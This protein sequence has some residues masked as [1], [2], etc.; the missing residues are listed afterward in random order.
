MGVQFRLEYAHVA[1]SWRGGGGL[2]SRPQATP[3]IVQF[4]TLI[5]DR[6]HHIPMFLLPPKHSRHLLEPPGITLG[7]GFQHAHYP[8]ALDPLNGEHFRC[9]PRLRLL[10]GGYAIQPGDP[11]RY[12]DWSPNDLRERVLYACVPG[13][14]WTGQIDG[15]PRK[16]DNPRVVAKQEP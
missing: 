4:L 16:V 14:R 6:Q 12:L 15:T 8:A 5:A 1:P 13:R 10:V 3:W 7:K 2:S 11:A 9:A